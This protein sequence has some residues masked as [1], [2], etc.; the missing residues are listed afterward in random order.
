MKAHSLHLPVDAGFDRDLRSG[1]YQ[2]FLWMPNLVILVSTSQDGTPRS[3]RASENHAT[4]SNSS[5]RGPRYV[6]NSLCSLKADSCI[7]PD[8]T[9]GLGSTFLGRHSKH[10]WQVCPP[11]RV[12]E[13][14]DRTVLVLISDGER[15]TVGN[16]AG[17]VQ[18]PHLGIWRSAGRP[19]CKGREHFWG[20]AQGKAMK[21]G[22][23]ILRLLSDRA[24]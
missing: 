2:T 8:S 16:A 18:S 3:D 4:F 17:N 11:C 6:S 10:C 21:V 14:D 24:A 22:S 9:S 7:S 20:R 5:F 23:S 1:S 13:Q 19:F 12:P 15:T